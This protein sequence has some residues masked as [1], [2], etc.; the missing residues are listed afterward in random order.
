M[1][2]NICVP[3]PVKSVNMSDI[4]PTIRNVI[5]LNPNL[6]ELRFDYINDVQNITKDF[7]INILNRIQ[8]KIPVICTLRDYSEGGQVKTDTIERIQILKLIIES[9]PVYVDIEI[10]SVD[11]I[12]SEIIPFA[13]NNK[14]GLIFSYHDFEKTPSY[15]E[16]SNILENFMKKLKN[17]FLIDQ[18]TVDKSVFKLIFTAQSFED[19][20][21]PLELCKIK[22]SKKL[23]LIS[24]CMGDLGLFSRILCVFSN[25]F[26]T[27]SSFEEK[28]A[29]G[30]INISD[31]RKILNLFNFNI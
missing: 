4:S 29:P 24:F 8:P 9:K 28:T 15:I 23:S 31:L 2:C 19:N 18:K 10:N 6:I 26:L 3:I 27:Y 20:F 17:E 14:V 13:S 16:A 7:V 5:K 25:S 21:I 1:K 11:A 22:S 30:Q 12:L